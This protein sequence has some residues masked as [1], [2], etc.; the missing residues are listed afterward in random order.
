[1]VAEQCKDSNE[2]ATFNTLEMIPRKLVL[3]HRV[4]ENLHVACICPFLIPAFDYASNIT[5]AASDTSGR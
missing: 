4:L 5:A 3:G 1:M 2:K